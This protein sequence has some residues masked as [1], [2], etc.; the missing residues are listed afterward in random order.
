MGTIWTD[1]LDSCALAAFQDQRQA[2]DLRQDVLDANETRRLPPFGFAHLCLRHW[3]RQGKSAIIALEVGCVIDRR[4]GQVIQQEAL[5]V[6]LRVGH[7]L[8]A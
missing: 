1:D 2:E 7:V 3:R 4:N 6:D 8:E 5:G